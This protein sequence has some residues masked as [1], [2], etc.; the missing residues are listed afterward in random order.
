[1]GPQRQ[2]QGGPGLAEAPDGP[3]A[4]LM[5]PNP[6]LPVR[7]LK[8]GQ[9]Q[10]DLT[11]PEPTRLTVSALRTESCDPEASEIRTTV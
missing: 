11:Y 2:R 1:M 8:S 7:V 9:G 3:R 5:P 6:L 4:L 10:Q